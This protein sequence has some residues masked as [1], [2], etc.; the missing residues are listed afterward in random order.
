MVIK[1]I[2]WR[3]WLFI[4]WTRQDPEN[5][6]AVLFANML[7]TNLAGSKES[8]FIRNDVARIL[9]KYGSLSEIK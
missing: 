3:R 1:W 4:K 2:L 8:I 7:K 5:M 6:G 9:S